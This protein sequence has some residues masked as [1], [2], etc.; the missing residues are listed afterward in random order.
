MSHFPRADAEVTP[1]TIIPRVRPY[2][3]GP[4]LSGLSEAAFPKEVELLLNDSTTLRLIPHGDRNELL[5]CGFNQSC[6]ETGCGVKPP[7]MHADDGFWSF[8]S[9][10]RSLA[11]ETGERVFPRMEGPVVIP[12][13]KIDAPL[14]SL[15]GFGPLPEGGVEK[16]QFHD[17]SAV[18]VGLSQSLGPAVREMNC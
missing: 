18:A 3:G 9:E 16:F 11:G 15:G 5:P 13:E 8:A 12:A 2:L 4:E 14:E 1:E 10:Q 17:R 6:S 7:T